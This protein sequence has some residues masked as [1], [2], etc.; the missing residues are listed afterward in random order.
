[1]KER[2]LWKKVLNQEKLYRLQGKIHK[3]I[4]GGYEITNNT[5][6]KESL[7]KNFKNH[8]LKKSLNLFLILMNF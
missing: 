1:M 5:K 7:F 8:Y 2:N 4:F 3:V 6:K